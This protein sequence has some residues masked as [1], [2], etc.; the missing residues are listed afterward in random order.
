MAD[1]EQ[2]QIEHTLPLHLKYRPA[3]FKDVRGQDA[4][5]KSLKA[6][7]TASAKPHA[8]AFTGPP[9]TGKTTLARIVATACNVPPEGVVEIDAA[10]NSGVD[11]MR[12][13]MRPLGY[14]GFGSSPNKMIIIDEAHGLSKQAFDSLL[15]TLEE[16][17]AHVFFALCTTNPSKLPAAIVT[18]CAAYALRPCDEK[19]MAD[20]LFDVCDV[21]GY[22]T[23]DGIVMAAVHAANGSPRQALVNL[24]KVHD[25]RDEEEALQ[26]LESVTMDKEIIDIC[27]LLIARKLNWKT[28]RDTIKAMPSPDAES[29]RI[30]IS[31][32]LAGC[33]MSARD[34]RD[35]SDLCAI[36]YKFSKPFN[37]TDKMMP[38]FIAFDDLLGN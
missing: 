31:C 33:V 3:N 27:R 26:L 34:D 4:I 20:M 35:I 8:Y 9:G 5:I 25:V 11:A 7:M 17:P 14:Q 2:P 32:Y 12:E 6:T 1:D 16:P 30:V 10:S 29:I 36:A 38:L 19:T 15:K 37:P 23:P 18:R 24:A 22:K 21:E 28:L 13:V